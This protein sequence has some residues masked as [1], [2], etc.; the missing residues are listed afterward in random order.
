MA[1]TYGV[2]EGSSLADWP[3]TYDDLEPYYERAEWEIGVSGYDD[4]NRFQGPRQPRLSPAPAA[5]HAFA[6][7]CFKR[8]ADTLGW[9]TTPVPLAHQ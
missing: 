2:P 9:N 3:I 4:A 1:S 5:G 7:Q 8:G 6:A